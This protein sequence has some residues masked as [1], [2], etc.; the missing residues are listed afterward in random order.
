MRESDLRVH[1]A[2]QSKLKVGLVDVPALESGAVSEAVGSLMGAGYE[3][4]LFDTVDIQSQDAVGAMLWDNA[5]EQPVFCAGSSGLTAAL[6][7]TWNARGML[8]DAHR[9]EDLSAAQPLLV[10]SGSCSETTGR[11]LAYALAHGYR[12]IALDPIALMQR[13]GPAHRSALEAARASLAAGD[14]TVL[15]TAMGPTG[16][17]SHGGELGVALGLLLRDLLAPGAVSSTPVR[18]VL[19]C[20]GDTASYAVQQ[21]GLYALT[22]AANLQPGCPLCCAH[23]DTQLNGL[24]LALKGGQVGSEDFFDVVR[25]G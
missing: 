3:A 22:W 14:D 20:G 5:R 19:L 16:A 7:S 1:L 10:V 11:Q 21:L 23:S 25:G 12:G 2:A 15:Y 18:R 6:I 8:P 17:S 9:R 24:E 4:I 13:N